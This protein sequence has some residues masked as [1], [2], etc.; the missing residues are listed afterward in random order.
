MTKSV[1][2]YYDYGSPTCYL[3]W[4]Q[5]PAI[6]AKHG[7][8]LVRKPVL[9]GGIFKAAG[10]GTPLAVPAKAA[11][12]MADIERHASQYGVPIVK[13][14]SFPFNSVPAMRGAIWASKQGCLDVYDRALF[15]A[16]W[17]KGADIGNLETLKGIVAG[18]G[19]DAGAFASS[20]QMDEIKKALI[21]ST[22]EAVAAGAF[23]APTFVIGKELHWGQDRLL[24]VERALAGQAA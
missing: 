3:A 13:S 22:N 4:T 7:G 11:W 21:D 20:I 19:L 16:A 2:F 10:N 17:V 24:W 1:T 15:E 14:P 6:C 5:L 12:M 8:K 18:A 9:L 23:G